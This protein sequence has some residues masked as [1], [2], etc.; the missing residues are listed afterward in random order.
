M[1]CKQYFVAQLYICYFVSSNMENLLIDLI[2]VEVWIDC[3]V[4]KTWIRVV[5]KDLIFCCKNYSEKQFL[6]FFFI[7]SANSYCGWCVGMC[8]PD[9]C[10]SRAPVS[11]VE[12]FAPTTLLPS[13]TPTT[14]IYV[15]L[16]LEFVIF[17][18]LH[19]KVLEML[20]IQI[21]C[22]F[23]EMS[24]KT[25]ITDL[26]LFCCSSCVGVDRKNW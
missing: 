22:C 14:L 5:C 17:C 26:N 13:F 15:F 10:D 23:V 4:G 21:N 25:K 12:A 6:D 16:S 7:W 19:H 2:K 1:I 3:L 24:Y 18:F 20:V 11:S 8:L 9:F